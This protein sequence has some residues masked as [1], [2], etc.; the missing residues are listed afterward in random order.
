[1]NE[2]AKTIGFDTGMWGYTS[3]DGY[4]VLDLY[5]H[6]LDPAAPQ[7][8]ERFKLADPLAQ[9]VIANP[10]TTFNHDDIVPKNKWVLHPI[11]NE[12]C[13]QFGIEFTLSTIH[14]DPHLNLVA[15]FSLHRDN[16]G[17]PFSERDRASIEHLL[18]ILLEAE[19]TNLLCFSHRYDTSPESRIY[20]QKGISTPNGTLLY[21]DEAFQQFVRT[22]WGDWKGPVL[23][24]PMR[25]FLSRK[26]IGS[27]SGIV[28]DPSFF[29]EMH[30]LMRLNSER[31]KVSRAPRELEVARLIMER[32]SNIEIANKLDITEAT[33]KDYV[34]KIRTKMGLVGQPRRILRLALKELLDTL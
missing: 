22:V 31:E 20:P 19:K 12:H 8:Y 24:E 10:G 3:A 13:K 17:S 6:H 26:Q 33:V 2:I 5:L 34:R 30:Q 27:E 7:S 4:Q 21:A 18:P 28:L 14:F 29:D 11:Y 1:M 16:P 15:F 32:L 23:P 25:K 9:A